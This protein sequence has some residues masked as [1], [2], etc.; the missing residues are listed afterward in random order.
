MIKLTNL[1]NEIEKPEN[2][3]APGQGPE[4]SNIEKKGFR[5]K[6]TTID[7]E[8]GKS[9]SEVEYEPKLKQIAA[10]LESYREEF[11]IVSKSNTEE[12]KTLAENIDTALHRIAKAMYK[13]NEMIQYKKRYK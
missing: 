7:P 1:I 10:D 5:L 13:L 11:K 8:T 6:N 9:S 3:Y 4:A 2:V 12:I